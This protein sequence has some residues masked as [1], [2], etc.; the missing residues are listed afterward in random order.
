MLLCCTSNETL[1]KGDARQCYSAKKKKSFKAR[2][3]IACIFA[4][5]KNGRKQYNTK[6]KNSSVLV[7]F[8]TLLG[9]NSGIKKGGANIMGY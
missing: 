9:A 6:G 7:V 5:S 4:K 1:N 3:Y 8:T 2:V